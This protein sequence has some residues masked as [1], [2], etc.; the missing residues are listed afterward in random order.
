MDWNRRLAGLRDRLAAEDA[1]ALLVSSQANV[2]YLTGFAGEGL[3]V[4][5]PTGAL[6]STDGRYKVEAA[7]M[8]TGV[9]ACFH[10]A[11]HL[12]GAYEYLG[13]I[14]VTSTGFEAE[15]LTYGSYLTL[16]EKLDGIELR[17]A[18]RWVEDLRVH[19]EEAEVEAMGGAAAMVDQALA[20]FLDGLEPGKTERELALD[21]TREL[22]AAGTDPPFPIIMASGESSARPHAVPGTRRLAE[23]DMLKID[24]GGQHEGYCS[25]MTRTFFIGEPNDKFRE[26]YGLVLAAQA[27]A[28][29]VVGPDVPAREVDQAARDIITVGG[30]GEA[31]SH[32]LGHGVGLQVHEGPRVSAKSEDVLKP[33]MVVTIEPGIYLEGWGGVRIE[34]LVLITP[35]GAEVLTHAPKPRYE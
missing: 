22:A 31:F 9:E 19:K 1:A 10:E 17:P 7:E 32:G 14:A 16:Q 12:A 11:G 35:D 3:L 24:V 18:R 8:A 25:D 26:V 4:L 27:Q 33:G 30:Y 5:T 29:S 34:D 15:A 21:L 28:L 13:A 20:R 6:L 2:R 23:G